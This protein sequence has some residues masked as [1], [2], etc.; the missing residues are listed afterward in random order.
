MSDQDNFFFQ[1]QYN[2]QYTSDKI[3]SKYQLGD[4]QLIQH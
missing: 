3:K 1:Y 4:Y 2:I